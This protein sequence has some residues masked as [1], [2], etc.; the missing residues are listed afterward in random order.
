MNEGQRELFERVREMIL[1]FLDECEDQHMFEERSHE[2]VSECSAA[3]LE[4]SC[5]VPDAFYRLLQEMVAKVIKETHMEDAEA[6][7][8]DDGQGGE[9]DHEMQDMLADESREFMLST[10]IQA[11]TT[12]FV[13]MIERVKKQVAKQNPQ[14]HDEQTLKATG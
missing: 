13:E 12:S 3:I 8:E 14:Q 7:M 11:K 5:A 1:L 10:I 2:A 6:E 4:A 9:S